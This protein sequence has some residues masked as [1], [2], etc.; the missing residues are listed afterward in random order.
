M[1]TIQLSLQN[2]SFTYYLYYIVDEIMAVV[3]LDNQYIG[4]TGWKTCSQQCWDQR[5]TIEL[6]RVS[7]NIIITQLHWQGILITSQ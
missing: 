7:T 4:Q 5:F 6:D 3:K 2:E 1:S